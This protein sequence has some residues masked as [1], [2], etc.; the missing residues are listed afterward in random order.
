MMV[1]GFGL[2]GAGVRRRRAIGR[3]TY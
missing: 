3:V 1:A 2:V